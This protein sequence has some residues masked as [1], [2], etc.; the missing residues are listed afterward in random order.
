MYICYLSVLTFHRISEIHTTETMKEKHLTT[1][2]CNGT[3][4]DRRPTADTRHTDETFEEID[5]P[6]QP[7]RYETRDWNDAP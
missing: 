2:V 3:C 6:P 5:P 1:K 7:P 4:S